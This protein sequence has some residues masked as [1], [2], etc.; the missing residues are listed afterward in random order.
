MTKQAAFF[1]QILSRNPSVI[2]E[3]LVI[4]G[5]SLLM[6]GLAQ[7]AIPLPFSPVPITGQTLGVS[8]LGLLLGRKRAVAAVVLY[9]S[10][11]A[12]G[13]PVFAA[14][15]SGILMGPTTGYLFG[16]VLAAGWIGFLADRG[17]AKSFIKAFLVCLSGSLFVFGCGA[18]WMSTFFPWSKV[19]AMG[20]VPFIAGDLL[21]CGFAAS[22]AGASAR[23]SKN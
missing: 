11:G 23:F 16:M 19:L 4:A 21:K 12:M 17:F 13:L 1:P 2:L 10:E 20:V 6:A 3:I 5:G 14:G 9:L 22:I 15:S 7:I 18:L 8:I